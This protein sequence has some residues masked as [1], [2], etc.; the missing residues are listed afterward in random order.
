MSNSNIRSEQMFGFRGH[1]P[2]MC[3]VEELQ[4]GAAKELRPARVGQ[5]QIL[6]GLELRMAA[7]KE[8]RLRDE[9]ELRL[10]SGRGRLKI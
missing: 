2:Q 10:C 7:V 5:L 3:A 8:L 4:L 6:A 9:K 1:A